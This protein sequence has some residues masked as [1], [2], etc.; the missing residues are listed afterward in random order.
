MLKKEKKKVHTKK[1]LLEFLLG[2]QS[3]GHIVSS[4]MRGCAYLHYQKI[5]NVAQ[6]KALMSLRMCLH[7]CVF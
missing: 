2:Q 4:K 1:K 3:A 7:F 5:P 6:M